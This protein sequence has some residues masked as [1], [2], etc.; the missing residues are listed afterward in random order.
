MGTPSGR[1]LRDFYVQTDKQV[2]DIH[3][4][5]RRLADLKSGKAEAS[6]SASASA[7]APAA[8]GSAAAEIE[9]VAP[10]APHHTATP[11]TTTPATAIA[12][13]DVPTAPAPAAAAA[14]ATEAA[15]LPSEPVQGS[16]STVPAPPTEPKA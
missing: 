8:A 11:A 4:E 1:K 12:A 3:E 10:T 2:R 15:A 14:A 7:P 5:A 9:K 16:S 13:P 6:A